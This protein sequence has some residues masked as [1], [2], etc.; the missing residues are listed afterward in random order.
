M[1]PAPTLRK[2]I[3]ISEFKARCTEELRAVEREGVTLEITRHGKVVAT[4]Q[5]PVAEEEPVATMGDW[6]GALRGTAV[7]SMDYDPHGPAWPDEDWEMN[8]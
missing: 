2:R 1:N 7:F 6:I 4:A 8:G 3:P 5:A